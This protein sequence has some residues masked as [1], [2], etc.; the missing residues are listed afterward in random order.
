MRLNTQYYLLNTTLFI[1]V[2]IVINLKLF[3]YGGRNH[4]KR[5]RTNTI[6]KA[7]QPNTSPP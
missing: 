3:G 4:R 5:F 7:T 6:S 1:S 2:K